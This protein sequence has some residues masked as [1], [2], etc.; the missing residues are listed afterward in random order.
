MDLRQLRYFVAVAEA[1]NISR[2]A[3][4]I[5]LTQPALSRQIKAL[6]AE[7]GQCLLER[8]AHS[9]RLTAAGELLLREAR[10]LL[11]HAEQVLER[12]RATGQGVQLRVGYA[13]SLAAELLSPAV[14]QFTQTHPNAR[15][16]LFDL[17]TAEML[18]GLAAETLDVAVTVGPPQETR[19]V[20]W[21]PLLRAPWQL[22][23]NAKDPLASRRRIPPAEVAARPL[24]MFCQRDYPEYWQVVM[25]WLRGHGARAKVAGEYDGVE[26]LLA[27]VAAGLGVALVTDRTR[28]HMRSRVRLKP[29]SSPPAPLC[30]AAGQRAARAHHPP[31]AVFLEE[32]RK[33]ASAPG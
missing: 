14:E 31:I 1:G 20:Q 21:T 22:A 32:L 25:S 24:V 4:Q 17:S 15:V 2:A 3:K 8:Q 28:G 19:D 33:A 27:A 18:A 23:V 16:E 10:D 7:I 26:S 11:R 6:E 5:Y 13:P 30:I 12:V 29:L 9:I